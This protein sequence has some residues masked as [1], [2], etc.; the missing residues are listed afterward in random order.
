MKK[1]KDIEK[2]EEILL[3]DEVDV[4]FSKEFY[5]ELYSTEASIIDIKITELIMYIWNNQKD[6]LNMS[7]VKE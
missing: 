3:I 6:D 4:F 7:K 2:A 5:G 1:T